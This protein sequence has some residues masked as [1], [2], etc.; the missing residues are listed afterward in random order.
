[1]ND[2]QRRPRSRR[3]WEE[4]DQET[5]DFHVEYSPISP[6]EDVDVI[7]SP[8]YRTV[9]EALD[10]LKKKLENMDAEDEEGES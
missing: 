8:K 4:D 10:A 5:L 9:Q 3:R 6:L 1:V 2:R 7:D